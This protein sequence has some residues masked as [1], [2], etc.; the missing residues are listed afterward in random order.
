MKP[1][2][3]KR[4]VRILEARGWFYVRSRGSHRYYRHSE[5]TELVNV[6]VHGNENLTPGSQRDTMRKAGLT[7]ADL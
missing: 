6:P 1:I 2:S 4:M 3:G 5:S 7:D